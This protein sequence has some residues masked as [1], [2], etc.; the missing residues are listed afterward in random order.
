MI[1]PVAIC[2]VLSLGASGAV[3]PIATRCNRR[4]GAHCRIL[5]SG[6]NHNTMCCV[7]ANGRLGTWHHPGVERMRACFNWQWTTRCSRILRRNAVLRRGGAMR[8]AELTV[9]PEETPY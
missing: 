8:G 6:L 4:L 5:W 7:I 9:R 3:E 1:S 2:R